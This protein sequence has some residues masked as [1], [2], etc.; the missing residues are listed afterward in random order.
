MQM[1]DQRRLRM[2][3]HMQH[4]MY[5]HHGNLMHAYAD[6]TWKSKGGR[7]S[8]LHAWFLTTYVLVPLL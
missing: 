6:C 2:S 1:F 4:S 5:S 3:V 7:V 8:V